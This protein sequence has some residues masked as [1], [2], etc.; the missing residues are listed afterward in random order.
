MR[1]RCGKSDI[2]PRS[3][4]TA[5]PF[6]AVKKATCQRRHE[7]AADRGH[8]LGVTLPIK[9]PPWRREC[10]DA[11]APWTHSRGDFAEQAPTLPRGCW[12]GLRPPGPSSEKRL[13]RL[14]ERG[15]RRLEFELRILYT[16][17]L[18]FGFPAS[19]SAA[20][21]LRGTIEACR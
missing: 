12:G 5:L 13:R 4:G 16:W 1:R 8:T 17:N 2:G 11:L 18:N 10:G 19:G 6:A 15:I 21:V 9:H 20:G 3:S 7:K 14:Q